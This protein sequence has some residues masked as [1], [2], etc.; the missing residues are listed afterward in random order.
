[1]ALAAGLM[2]HDPSRA[3]HGMPVEALIYERY[4]VPLTARFTAPLL[5]LAPPARG[6]RILD[7]ACGTGLI[8]RAAAP[9]VGPSGLAV[10]VDRSPAMIAVAR[11]RAAEEGLTPCC[12]A[13]M[14]AQAL[15]LADAAFDSAYCQFGL[16]LVA[17]PARA[18]AELARVVRPGGAVAAVVWSEPERVIG[19]AAYIAAVHAHVPGA[20]PPEHHPVFRLGA[21]GA[22][23]ALLAAA[24]LA[25]DHEE[26]LAV[27]DRYPDAEAYWTWASQVV[28][29][30]VAADSGWAARLITD[31][32]TEVQERVR[33]A[34]LARVAAYQQPDGSL[35][36]PSEAILVRACR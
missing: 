31:Y 9:Q 33:A 26:R 19:F 11:R 18:A 36:L 21:P 22:L 12:F 8:A 35:A 14:D 25:V 1:M 5:A 34:A 3:P 30:P 29:F 15:A 13:V 7:V 23:A 28:G 32:P 17:D 16:M 20:R 4:G 10:G 24:G 6:W 2:A 27:V